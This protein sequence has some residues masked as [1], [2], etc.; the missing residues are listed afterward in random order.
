MVA[1]GTVTFNSDGSIA[2]VNGASPASGTTSLGI[3]WAPAT[4]L[5][6][7]QNINLN[8]GTP[9]QTSGITQF[10]SASTALNSSVDGEPYGTATGVTVDSNGFV[11][12]QF[13]NG[14]SRKVYQVPL[15]T[16]QNSDGLSAVS[17]SAYQ[18]STQ[19]GTATVDAP[20]TGSAGSIQSQALEAS[21]VD[22]AT[23]FTN[24]ITTQRAYSAAARIVTTADTMLQ[25]LEQLPST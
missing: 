4:G 1:N 5:A 24:L 20:K 11:T 15:A 22:L 9:G 10:N 13:S 23:E 16:F 17:G 3:N 25:T 7:P 12:A 21:T 6:S 2:N 18:A 14:M 19:S 8:F